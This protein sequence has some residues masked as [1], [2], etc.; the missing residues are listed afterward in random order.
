M[1][2]EMEEKIE[3]PLLR[4]GK[5][6]SHFG[7]KVL[8]VLFVLS[9][10][11]LPGQALPNENLEAAEKLFNGQEYKKAVKHLEKVTK[12]DP[13]NTRAW[14]LMGDSYRSWGKYKQ[15][16]KSYDKAI[17]LDA[18]QKEALMGMGMS[19]GNMRKHGQAIVPLK[20]LVEIDPSNALAHFYLGVSYEALRSMNRAWEEY[21]ILKSLDKELADKLYH[22]IFW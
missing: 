16:I 2:D 17:G 18:S 15:A 9:I 10:F 20:H 5:R 7:N 14:V 21:E 1:K 11:I 22:I 3:E 8:S 6:R 13:S 12:E 19:Y 4:R